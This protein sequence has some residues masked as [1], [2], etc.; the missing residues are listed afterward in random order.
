MVEG[1]VEEGGGVRWQVGIQ[2]EVAEAAPSW[3]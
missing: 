1:A 2:M 3:P